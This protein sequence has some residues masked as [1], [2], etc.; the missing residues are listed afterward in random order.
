MEWLRAPVASVVDPIG[1]RF[2]VP[3]SWFSP[4]VKD[5]EAPCSEALCCPIRC[6]QALAFPLLVQPSVRATLVEDISRQH[7]APGRGGQGTTFGF[8]L[9]ASLAVVPVA[10]AEKTRTGGTGAIR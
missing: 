9:R 4:P 2:L 6:F 1:Q 3:S 7:G 10:T 8:R 5:W